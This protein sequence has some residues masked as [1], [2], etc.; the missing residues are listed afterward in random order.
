[1]EREHRN[2]RW[3]SR[4]GY[5][6]PVAAN[7]AILLLTNL[8]AIILSAASA[9]ML[10]GIRGEAT[11]TGV[12]TWVRRVMVA[13]VMLMVILLLP[14]V[15]NVVK[16]KRQGQTRPLTYP[17]AAHV[18]DAVTSYLDTVPGVTLITIARVSSEPASAVSIM[19]AAQESMP[20]GLKDELTRIVQEVRGGNPS[21]R[22]IALRE[23]GEKVLESEG[24]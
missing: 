6:L 5:Q 13:L 17:V 22:I 20:V 12:S 24:S 11:G 23:V 1:M 2:I 16:Q 9:F 8:V 19:L 15:G 4:L 14:L 7:S 3:M 10:L 21:V 18:Q